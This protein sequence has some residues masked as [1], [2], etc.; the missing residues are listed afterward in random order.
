MPAMKTVRSSTAV[1]ALDLYRGFS[2]CFATVGERAE[3]LGLSE[4]AVRKWERGE[5]RFV[6]K[7]SADRALLVHRTCQRLE[8]RFSYKGDVGAYLLHSVY[9]VDRRVR[10]LDL[11]VESADPNVAVDLL[12]ATRAAALDVVKRAL[13]EEAFSEG[14]WAAV[15]APVSDD[16]RELEAELRERTEKHGVT[17]AL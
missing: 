16:E 8:R 2:G 3:A 17:P 1:R 15:L 14:A 6:K 4:T 7:S 11:V 12:E 5:L 10:P 13:P 9:E